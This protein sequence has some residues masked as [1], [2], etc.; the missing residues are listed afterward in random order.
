MSRNND[1]FTIIV[2]GILCFILSIFI[3]YG[4]KLKHA[5]KELNYKIDSLQTIINNA[6]NSSFTG[7]ISSLVYNIEYRDSI[8]YN[9]KK[10]YIKDVEVVQN[11]P[12]STTISK[13]N[14][15]VWTD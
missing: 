1:T 11:L 5:N 12:D 3:A 2:F 6:H 15:L 4:A 8:I 13:F 7:D 14:E 9:I 10:E